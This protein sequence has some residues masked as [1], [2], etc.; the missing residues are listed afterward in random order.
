MPA[1]DRGHRTANVDTA[2]LNSGRV[3][4]LMAFSV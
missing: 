3:L 1:P 2:L 4:K